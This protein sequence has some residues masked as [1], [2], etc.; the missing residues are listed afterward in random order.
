MSH[1]ML[2]QALSSTVRLGLLSYSSDLVF[3]SWVSMMLSPY[4]GPTLQ[5]FLQ[6]HSP[7]IVHVF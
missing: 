1:L 5:S 4:D 3:I 2:T 7:A 6:D